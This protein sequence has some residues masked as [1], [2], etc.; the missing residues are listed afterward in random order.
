MMLSAFRPVR[1]LLLSVFILMSGSGFM[2]TLISLQLEA[3]GTSP[4]LIG[5]VATAYFLG[6]TVGA[7]R[8]TPLIQRVGHIRAFAAFLSLFS[9][10]TLAY[11]VYENTMFWAGLRFVD[12]FCMAG[13]FICV[14]SWLNDRAEP[15]AR[16]MV[17]AGYM[18]VLYSGQALGQFLLTVSHDKP[19]MPFLAASI[20][21][22]LAVIPVALTRVAGPVIEARPPLSIKALYRISPLGIV[23]AAVTGLMLG[24]FYGLGAVHARKL[25]MDMPGT[26]MFMSAVI[27]GGIVLQWP[28]GRLSDRIDRRQVIIGTFAAAVA[29]SGVMALMGAPGM[30]ML[31]LGAL[32]GGLSFALYP[33]CVAHANDRLT[34]EE[35]V[36]A[37]GGLVL[38]YSVG[39]AAGPVPAAALMTALGPAGL[40]GFIG[41]CA[42]GGCAFALWREK[43]G[44]SLPNDM[45]Q[46]YQTLP[47]TTPMASAMDPQAPDFPNAGQ[48]S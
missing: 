16:G 39:A 34:P 29:V 26:A 21:L 31:V 11:A 46:P 6:L 38:A 7:L 19:S 9:A 37:S 36:G 23:G 3:S 13:I 2:A 20:L 35:R 18:V 5:P 10:S 47:R 33:L 8:I 48:R 24:A 42:L 22:S 41:A 14:E 17:L 15:K 30:A 4:M 1:S 27:V 40:Y 43:A 12:G 25:G 45:Q 28:I 44:D 32:F